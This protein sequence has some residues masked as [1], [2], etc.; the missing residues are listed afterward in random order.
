MARKGWADHIWSDHRTRHGAKRDDRRISPTSSHATVARIFEKSPA[1]SGVEPWRLQA[2]CVGQPQA[3]RT[4]DSGAWR[5]RRG[6]IGLGYWDGANGNTDPKTVAKAAQACPRLVGIEHVRSGHLTAPVDHKIRHQR[7]LSRLPRPLDACRLHERNPRAVMGL[8]CAAVVNQ[9]GMSR[10][11]KSGARPQ[12][13]VTP[14]LRWL[15][16]RHRLPGN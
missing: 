9:G 11:G 4:G 14:G 7:D 10:I 15:S 12:G 8:R 2:V 1:S 16:S 5:R 13:E 3:D 6:S